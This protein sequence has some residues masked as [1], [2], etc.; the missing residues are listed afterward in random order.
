MTAAGLRDE[1]HEACDR[2][3]DLVDQVEQA[4]RPDGRAIPALKRNLVFE[5]AFLRS[6]LGWEAF[7]E[8]IFLHYL[9]GRD[10]SN[11]SA[12]TPI[13]R[14]RSIEIARA[15]VLGDFDYLEWTSRATVVS[16]AD[17]WLKDKT[18]FESG[19]NKA[20]ELKHMYRLRNRIAHSSTKSQDDF[21][22][23]RQHL[24]PNRPHYRGFGPGMVLRHSRPSGRN[25]DLLVTQLKNAATTIAAGP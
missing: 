7:L 18:F 24:A 20:P 25:L 21:A 1:F 22:S 3:V 12:C 6:L 10:G 4:R 5:T 15:V 19:F 8:D 16:R 9:S 2:A 11:G 13:V 17:H 14:P 23:T